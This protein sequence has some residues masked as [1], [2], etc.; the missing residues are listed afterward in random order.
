MGCG[1]DLNES[2]RDGCSAAAPSRDAMFSDPRLFAGATV[3]TESE[4]NDG[5]DAAG[6]LKLSVDRPVVVEG[7]ITSREDLDL[8]ALP[9]CSFGDHLL[10]ELE[11]PV[12]VSL[13]ISLLDADHDVLS[14]PKGSAGPEGRLVQLSHLFREDTP[15]AYLAIVRSRSSEDQRVD[16]TVRVALRTD[17]QVPPPLRQYVMLA[18][19]PEQ[20]TY[21]GDMA[22]ETGVG[23]DAGRVADR[24]SSRSDRIEAMMVDQVRARFEGFDV[25]ILTPDDPVPDTA[26]MSVV[27]FKPRGVGAAGWAESIDPYN[28]N[29]RQHAYVYYHG[30]RRADELGVTDEQLAHGLANVVAHEIGHLLG[31]SHTSDPLDIMDA[32]A[33]IGALFQPRSFRR[34]P[35]LAG[36]VPTAFQNAP[37]LLLQ[38]VGSSLPAEAT[39]ADVW[40]PISQQ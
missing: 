19:D 37:L 30:F 12:G 6:P 36:P 7:R 20:N 2:C 40:E 4:A 18:L 32:T 25:T 5:F 35:L 8:Y 15:V 34:S 26:L 28:R 1:V 23:F 27:H 14:V 11:R 38:T 24:F 3:I 10:V 39:A 33:T 13:A 16:Y 9:D 31:L 17:E 29:Q 22:D 21:L